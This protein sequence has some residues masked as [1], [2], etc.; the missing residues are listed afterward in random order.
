MK[1]AHR[2]SF[3]LAAMLIAISFAGAPAIAQEDEAAVL[4]E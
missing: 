1:S 4:N 3:I 2:I